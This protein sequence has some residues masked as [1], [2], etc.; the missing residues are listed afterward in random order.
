MISWQ[1][2]FVGLKSPFLVPKILVLQDIVFILQILNQLKLRKFGYFGTTSRFGKLVKT[3]G[4]PCCSS[5][6]MGIQLAQP[7]L[8]S[9]FEK[10]DKN[11]VP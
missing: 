7:I 3:Q 11:F 6:A 5:K 10:I 8:M 9:I 1:R 4:K 2:Q